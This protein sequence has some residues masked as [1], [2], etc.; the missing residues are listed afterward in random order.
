MGAAPAPDA[1]DPAFVPVSC[2]EVESEASAAPVFARGD[3][4]ATHPVKTRA[5]ATAIA[6]DRALTKQAQGNSS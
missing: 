5:K 1:P 3:S 2:P 4:T 6:K